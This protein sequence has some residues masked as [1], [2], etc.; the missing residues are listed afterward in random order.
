MLDFSSGHHRL[1]LAASGVQLHLSSEQVA[2]VRVN[3]TAAGY[4]GEPGGVLQQGFKAS[5]TLEGI[6][7]FRVP[8]PRVLSRDR[9]HCTTGKGGDDTTT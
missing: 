6:L 9:V 4:G 2:A 3:R 5:L 8:G 1:L 7:A